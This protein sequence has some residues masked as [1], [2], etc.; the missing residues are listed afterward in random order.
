M[1]VF[2]ITFCV[3]FQGGPY[4]E[5]LQGLLGAYACYRPDVGYVSIWCLVERKTLTGIQDDNMHD[6]LVCR[7]ICRVFVSFLA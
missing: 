4:H 2:H 6:V 5:L 7:G 3:L 1:F